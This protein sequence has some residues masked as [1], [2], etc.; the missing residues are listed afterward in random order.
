MA[1]KKQ[2]KKLTLTPKVNKE[3]KPTEIEP[4]IISDEV[5]RCSCCGHKYKKQ[6]GKFNKSKSPIYRGNNGYT[7][8]C[9]KCISQ[10]YE[11]YI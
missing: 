11:G 5:Y 9:K 6:E 3:A 7:T 4:N 2:L 1:A 8:I 10:I